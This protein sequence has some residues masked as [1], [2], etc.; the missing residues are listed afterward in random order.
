MPQ[1]QQPYVG[2]VTFERVT[3][4]E[5]L[6]DP[7]GSTSALTAQHVAE[8]PYIQVAIA[9]LAKDDQELEASLRNADQDGIEAMME[10]CETFSSIADR[11]RACVELC[12]G[13]Q[14][15]IMVILDRLTHGPEPAPW[16]ED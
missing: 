12:N 13:A 2:G 15:R 4:P 5:E 3:T 8:L 16:M 10:A 14:A 1:E 9:V 11:H 6:T 7:R